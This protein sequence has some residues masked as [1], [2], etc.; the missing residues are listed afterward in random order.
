MRYYFVSSNLIQDSALP[1][2]VRL[3][4]YDRYQV[5]T[6]SNHVKIVSNAAY[7]RSTSSVGS[8]PTEVRLMFCYNYYIY[9]PRL[10]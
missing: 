6:H 10:Y 3:L 1:V 8:K 5:V 2:R 4:K 9:L 7:S